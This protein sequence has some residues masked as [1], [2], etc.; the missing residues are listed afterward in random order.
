[1]K[2]TPK[3]IFMNF[4]DYKKLQKLRIIV[5]PS[6]KDILNKTNILNRTDISSKNRRRYRIGE[7]SLPVKCLYPDNKIL[8]KI[9]QTQPIF[10][11]HGGIQ[12]TLPN[13]INENLAYL[14][15]FICGDGNLFK[16]EKR[17]YIV[18]IDNK[19]KKILEK[20]IGYD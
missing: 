4:E 12:V 15:G 14:T 16:T 1:M 8:I 17:D 9:M 11:T 7:R 6:I 13:K 18:T 19:E 20:N 10:I 3:E 5:T 2:N